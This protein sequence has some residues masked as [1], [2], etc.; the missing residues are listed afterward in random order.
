MQVMNLLL[1]IVV[2]YYMVDIT[3]F[4]SRKPAQSVISM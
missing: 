3:S 4:T 1:S 2:Y